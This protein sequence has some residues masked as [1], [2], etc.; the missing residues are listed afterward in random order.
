MLQIIIHGLLNRLITN[1]NI[2]AR[3][4]LQGISVKTIGWSIGYSPIPKV[5]NKPSNV[6]SYK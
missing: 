5:Q 3:D 4:G 2:H 6:V 1:D